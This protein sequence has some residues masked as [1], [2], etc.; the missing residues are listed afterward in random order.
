MQKI[1]GNAEGGRVRS[2]SLLFIANLRSHSCS[3]SRNP[4]SH[5]LLF[6]L[7]LRSHALSNLRSHPSKSGEHCTLTLAA[8][9][10]E[11]MGLAKQWYTQRQSDT[12][13]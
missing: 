8:V 4:R 13:V 5:S 1:K 6:L 10:K 12:K 3:L 2:H 11:T 7:S 9:T